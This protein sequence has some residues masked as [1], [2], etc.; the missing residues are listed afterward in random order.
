METE[1]HV[2]PEKIIYINGDEKLSSWLHVKNLCAISW[3]PPMPVTHISDEDNEKSVQEME[4]TILNNSQVGKVRSASTL[5]SFQI[6]L[7]TVGKNLKEEMK[8]KKDKDKDKEKEKGSSEH[9]HG[10]K[11]IEGLKGGGHGEGHDNG[12]SNRETKVTRVLSGAT[13]SSGGGGGGGGGGSSDSPIIKSAGSALKTGITTAAATTTT[14]ATTKPGAGSQFPPSLSLL[15][16]D[17]EDDTLAAGASSI[18]PSFKPTPMQGMNPL[19]HST[20]LPPLAP[21]HPLLNSDLLPL[22]ST[23]HPMFDPQSATTPHPQ[24]PFYYH[25][26]PSNPQSNSTTTPL[27]LLDSDLLPLHSIP[28]L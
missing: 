16:V 8:N 27:P 26:T 11:P 4:Q 13:Q 9:E 18:A 15:S 25:S 3:N 1:F 24:T 2:G 20:P 12:P 6:D 19:L 14:T 28:T 17:E 22:H 23:P 5:P 10:H 21:P 7:E